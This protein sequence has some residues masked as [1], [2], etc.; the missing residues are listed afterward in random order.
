MSPKQNKHDN[1]Y[2]HIAG[3]YPYFPITLDGQHYFEIIKH[4]LDQCIGI[5]GYPKILN[6]II[7]MH[8]VRLWPSCI[9]ASYTVNATMVNRACDL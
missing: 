4:D 8:S 6:L 3:F 1:I 7:I 9:L 2:T 5:D